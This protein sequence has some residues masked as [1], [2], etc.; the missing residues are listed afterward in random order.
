MEGMVTGTVSSS[1]KTTS[2]YKHFIEN[3]LMLQFTS[4]IDFNKPDKPAQFGVSLGI[5]AM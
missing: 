5:G 1:L 2:T 3:I 4:M